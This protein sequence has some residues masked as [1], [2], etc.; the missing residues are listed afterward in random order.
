MLLYIINIHRG[1]GQ[2]QQAPPF[3]LPLPTENLGP[4]RTPQ[5]NLNF[6]NVLVLCSPWYSSL[7]TKRVRAQL[8]ASFN[9]QRNGGE[10]YGSFSW[11]ALGAAPCYNAKL[12]VVIMLTYSM[13]EPNNFDNPEAEELT[14]ISK[15]ASINNGGDSEWYGTWS[16]L[17]TTPCQ[18]FLTVPQTNLANTT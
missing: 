9:F 16:S 17:G 13:K 15:Q 5:N 18:Y 6:S 4:K 1:K 14:I 8:Q 7:H 11:S 3:R 10:W 2:V 12:H